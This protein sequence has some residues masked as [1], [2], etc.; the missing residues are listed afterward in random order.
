MN[1]K[2]YMVV[3]NFLPK[4]NFL[5]LKQ[6]IFGNEFPWY[7]TPNITF[8]SK[9]SNGKLFY[10]THLFYEN[11]KPNSL[12]Y[13]LIKENLLNFLNIKS[14]IRVK[15]NFYPN[16]NIDYLNEKHADFEYNH[17]GALFSLNTNNG[18]TI[19]NDDIIIKSVENRIIFFDPSLLHDSKNCSDEKVRINI[20]INYF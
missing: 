13:D 15:A 17:K 20:N 4:E 11:Y 3:D 19:M 5:F 10:M 12:F 14:L 16:Q 7:Y 18:G 2:D 8:K 9:I 6:I 1:N